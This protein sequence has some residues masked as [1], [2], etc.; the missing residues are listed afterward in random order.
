MLILHVFNFLTFQIIL[1]QETEQTEGVKN[2]PISEHRCWPEKAKQGAG[3]SFDVPDGGDQ[4]DVE[5]QQV[6]LHPHHQGAQARCKPGVEHPEHNER[7]GSILIFFESGV[8][9]AN[10]SNPR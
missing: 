10:C 2:S 3:V 8:P 9:K 5:A 1:R 4:D 6:H 7:G